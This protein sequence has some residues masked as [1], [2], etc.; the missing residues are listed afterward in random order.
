MNAG[1]MFYVISCFDRFGSYVLR[2]VTTQL[3]FL[4]FDCCCTFG[5]HTLNKATAPTWESLKLVARKLP[6]ELFTRQLLFFG[7]TPIS[8][9]LV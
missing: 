1:N 6:N 5:T 3:R 7:E 4:G 9:F 2:C 8:V